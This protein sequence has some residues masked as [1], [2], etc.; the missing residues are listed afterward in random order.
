MKKWKSN[1]GRE[2]KEAYK[3]GLRK[4]EAIGYEKYKEEET[5]HYQEMLDFLYENGVANLLEKKGWR[6]Y[7]NRDYWIHNKAVEGNNKD[8]T[9]YGIGM[10]RAM[11][12]ELG[13][14]Y[15]V[16]NRTS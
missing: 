3:I 6:S 14:P 12:I 8:V 5:S 4:G 11:M 13:I 10:V 7:Y 16:K 2:E 15:K 9:Y 1:W